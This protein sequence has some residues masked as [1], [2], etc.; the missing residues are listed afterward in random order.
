MGELDA[1]RRAIQNALTALQDKGY[2]HI[3]LSGPGNQERSITPL[4]TVEGG[5]DLCKKM[6]SAEKCAA[7]KNAPT[8]AKKCTKRKQVKK[9]EYIRSNADFDLFWAAY[10]KKKAKQDARK[11]FAKV[12]VPLTVLLDALSEHKKSGEWMKGGGKYIP[13]PATWLNG[14]RWEDELTSEIKEEINYEPLH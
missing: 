12:D 4:V 14:Q 7:Q 8:Y 10:P 13:Y 2:I 11:A 6:R 3:Q 5:D 1:K 9:E